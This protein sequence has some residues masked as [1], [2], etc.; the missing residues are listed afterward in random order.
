MDCGYEPI[1]TMICIFRSL[2]LTFLITFK[3]SVKARNVNFATY[4]A[5]TI[6]RDCSTTRDIKI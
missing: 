3:D 6:Y 1:I 5:E 2:F 4:Q